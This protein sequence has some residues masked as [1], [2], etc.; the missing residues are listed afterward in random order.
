MLIR[1]PV[2]PST[3]N[4]FLNV[5]GR[6]RIAS[7]QYRAWRTEAGLKL[8][9]AK[10]MPFGKAKVQVTL[11]V[12]RKP[13]RRDIDNFAKGPLDLLVSHKVID[14]DRYVERLNIE[15]HD[16]ADLLLSVMPYEGREG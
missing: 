10:P 2:P 6:G 12:P 9:L 8:N 16:D 11:F 5:R 7:P 1:L 14:D 13:A 4:L 15:R 3:N